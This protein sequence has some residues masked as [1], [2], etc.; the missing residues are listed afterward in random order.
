[1]SS[2]IDDSIT[3][4]EAMK[5]IRDGRYVMPA[6]QRQF[7]W[8]MGQ[9]EK[10]WDSLLLDYPISTFLF[11]HVDSN[12]TEQDTYFCGFLRDVVFSMS[13]QRRADSAN[14]EL[15]SIDTSVTDTAIL[16][17]QQRLTAL[18]LSLFGDASLRKKYARKSGGSTTVSKLL[19]ELNESK[20]E[21][22]DDEF[23][24]KKFDIRFSE[25]VARLSPTQFEIRKIISD[26]FA[27]KEKREAAIEEEIKRVPTSSKEYAR[28]ILNKLCEKVYDEPMIRYTLITDMNQDDALEMF[29]RFNSGGKVLGKADITMSILEA[30]WPSAK[31]EFGRVLSE[32]YSGFGT[33]FIIRSALMLYGNVVK[34]NINR[35][36]AEDLKNNWAD[37]KQALSHLEELLACM[38]IDVQRFRSSWN[39]LLPVIYFIYQNPNN[40]EDNLEDVEAYMARAILFR[41]FQ[42]GTTNKLQQIRSNINEF[43]LRLTIEMLD[44]M[45]DLRVTPAKIDDILESEKGGRIAGEALYLLNR[46][47]MRSGVRYEQDHLHPDDRFNESKPAGVDMD[48]WS[49]WRGLKNKLA[50][51]QYLEGRSNGSKNSMPLIE[52]YND[53]TADQQALFKKQALIPD[54]VS[55]EISAFGEFYQK[56]RELFRSKLE[57]ML[58]WEGPRM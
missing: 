55:L 34:S 54:E 21:L 7:V 30:Y 35:T 25:K 33:D 17:G 8:S 2:F 53:M 1:M 22:D 5:N 4:Y 47:W 31:T 15:L 42:S 58:H 41:Y 56:R 46:E 11:W 23:N 40:Y 29:V 32:S 48:T 26:R 44:Q 6:F 36:V 45:S 12:N 16:D 13:N 18:Y 39:V 38:D 27:D 50:N 19:V 43:D 10:L 20:T 49:Q 14:Y 51:L 3:I 57:V 28:M 37:F 9:I 52:Y 24:S